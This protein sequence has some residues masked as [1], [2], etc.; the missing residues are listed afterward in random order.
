[1]TVDGEASVSRLQQVEPR[2]VA[3]GCRK[4]GNA[5]TGNRQQAT[6]RQA[7]A[8]S[9]LAANGWRSSRSEE[10]AAVYEIH[11][12]VQPDEDPPDA[13][14]KEPGDEAE[15]DPVVRPQRELEVDGYLAAAVDRSAHYVEAVRRAVGV[16]DLA[17]KEFSAR[18][19]KTQREEKNGR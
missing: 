18:G 5:A 13:H 4:H 1:M 14:R 6:T 2:Q 12:A 9:L 7:N 3:T 8:T 19:F 10:G 11:L 16:R 15:E 17:A